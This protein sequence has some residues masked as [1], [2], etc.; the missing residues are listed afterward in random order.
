MINDLDLTDTKQRRLAGFAARIVKLLAKPEVQNN[1]PLVSV[2]D[3]LLGAVYA[4]IAARQENFRGKMGNSEF[5]PILN[6]AKLIAEGKPKNSGNWMAG[7]HFNSA[8]FRISAVFDRLPKSLAGCKHGEACCEHGA[9]ARYHKVKGKAWQNQQ[10]HD[11]RK[12][13]NAIKHEAI[14]VYKGR[15]ANLNAACA[16]VNQILDL[17]EALA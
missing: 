3:D 5:P 10:L 4:L 9:A 7:F 1:E 17:A 16:A 12:E 2:I 15:Q 6:R 11:I 14:G 8:M 13:V